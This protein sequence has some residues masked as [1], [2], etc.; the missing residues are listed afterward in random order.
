MA[1]VQSISG[2]PL[3]L[4]LLLLV[5][6]GAVLGARAPADVGSH[7]YS[8]SLRR[9]GQHICGGAL[10]A[11]KWALT[12]AHCVSLGGGLQSYPPRSYDV[13]CGSIQRLLG[14]QLVALSQIIIQQN[15][16]SGAA[17]GA[18]DLALLELQSPVTLNDYTKPIDLAQV[19]PAVGSQITF[20]GWGSAQADGSLSHGLQVA[21]RLSL[22]PADCQKEL[23]LEQEDLLCLAPAAEDLTGLC[24]GDAGAP[25]VFSNQLVAIA[26]FFAGG[27]ASGQPDGY[28][29]VTQHLDWIA[30]NAV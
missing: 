29:D 1:L 14:G 13:R 17:P 2:Q 30:E 21:S 10:I 26:A 9:N 16:S 27:C 20:S 23:F 19:R 15:Y 4:L 6:L 8:I 25:A 5:A 18:N 24:S 7:P 22:S 11:P 12:A 3:L 28:V